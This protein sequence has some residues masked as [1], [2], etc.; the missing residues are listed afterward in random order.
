RLDKHTTLPNHQRLGECCTDVRGFMFVEPS[1]VSTARSPEAEPGSGG[2]PRRQQ[3][4]KNACPRPGHL[5]S[6]QTSERA[7]SIVR[8]A[9]LSIPPVCTRAKSRL[10]RSGT[11]VADLDLPKR[12]RACR[13]A[14][15]KPGK[16]PR[17]PS[18]HATN[19]NRTPVPACASHHA[20][21]VS[22]GD[23]R[24]LLADRRQ[25]ERRHGRE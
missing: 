8:G 11:P 3:R 25:R 19:P 21:R 16:H 5:A 18:K 14:S 6:E 7:R 4:R 24:S 15:R 20:G 22:I 2:R 13:H 1:P 10:T 9:S 12:G 17:L 23:R